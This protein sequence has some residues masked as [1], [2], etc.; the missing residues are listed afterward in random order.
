MSLSPIVETLSIPPYDVNTYLVICPQTRRAAVIDPAGEPDRILDA[1]ASHGARVLLILHTHGHADHVQAAA[2]LREACGAPV[3][4]HADDDRFFA[5][6]EVRARSERELGLPPGP[7]A[8]RRLADDDRLDL[9]R[10]TVRVLHTPGHTPGSVCYLVAGHLFTGDTLFV[11]DVGRTDLAGGSL[12]RLLRSL[13]EKIIDLPS[14]TVV[15]PGHD[16]GETPTTTI[17]RE[18][19]ENPYITDFILDAEPPAED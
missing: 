9:G 2:A 12:E 7:P 6:P 16:Y 4:M 5:D 8:D 3:C 10:L 18:R 11:G 19:Q 1:A 17:G 13:A 14:D 15:R